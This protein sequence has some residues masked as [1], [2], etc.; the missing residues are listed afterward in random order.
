MR[1]DA[2]ASPHGSDKADGNQASNKV[3]LFGNSYVG[4]KKEKNN[5]L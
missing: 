4:S 3:Q 2:G 5:Q 1:R